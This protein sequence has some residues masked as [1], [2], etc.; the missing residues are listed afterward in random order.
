MWGVVVVGG[1]VGVCVCVW[2]ECVCVC[3]GGPCD[4]LQVFVDDAPQ[5]DRRDE[6]PEPPPS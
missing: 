3:D 6:Q 2:G 1:G 5:R 4:D